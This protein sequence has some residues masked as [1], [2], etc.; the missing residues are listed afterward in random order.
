MV[1]VSITGCSKIMEISV[2]T[3]CGKSSFIGYLVI[4]LFINL[5]SLRLVETCLVEVN[6]GL[7]VFESHYVLRTLKSKL[8][9]SNT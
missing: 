8:N 3:S 6:T 7:K 9:K 4:T 2:K 1:N 5:H